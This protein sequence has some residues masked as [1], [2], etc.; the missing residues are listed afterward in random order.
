MERFVKAIT[1][2]GVAL[3]AGLWLVTLFEAGTASH[4][5]GIAFFL[6]GLGGL[7]WG[8]WEGITSR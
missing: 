4:L 2:G 5:F 1:G 3:V 7:S 8:I 6:V